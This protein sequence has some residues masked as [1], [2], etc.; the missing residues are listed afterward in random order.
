LPGSGNL[1]K[2]KIQQ[3][4]DR[5]EADRFVVVL[6]VVVVVIAVAAADM[7]DR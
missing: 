3:L 1:D 5:L 4:M 7:Q 2:S 6:V